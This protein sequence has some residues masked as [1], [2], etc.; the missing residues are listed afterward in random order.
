MLI[1]IPYLIDEMTVSKENGV[2]TGGDCELVNLRLDIGNGLDQPSTFQPFNINFFN[3][4]VANAMNC[5]MSE[6]ED[7]SN[8]HSLQVEDIGILR[9]REVDASDDIPVT[10][11]GDKVVS[12]GSCI[13]HH[14]NF[15]SSHSGLERIDIML[16]AKVAIVTGC[17]DD[18]DKM[19]RFYIQVS[20]LTV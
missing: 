1:D 11:R 18:V 15:I 16:A 12:L 2:G 8:Y 5:F 14:G 6:C 4:E 3:V 9:H 17:G 13:F 19:V 7:G 10:G 20:H